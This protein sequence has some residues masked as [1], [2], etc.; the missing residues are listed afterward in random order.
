MIVKWMNVF[1]RRI[2]GYNNGKVS[3]ILESLNY[4]IKDCGCEERA[5]EASAEFFTNKSKTLAFA[6]QA[7]FKNDNDLL[8]PFYG[9]VID[10]K[11]VRKKFNGD[12]DS[13]Y[14]EVR[15]VRT[16]PRKHDIRHCEV[17][18]RKYNSIKGIL[19]VNPP[20]D[21]IYRKNVMS[22]H[23]I[24]KAYAIRHGLKIYEG[25]EEMIAETYR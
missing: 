3:Q 15:E 5:K 13:G 12:I 6:M 1:G 10:R 4:E 22:L 9:L 14:C 8:V 11:A 17:I 21:Y 19:L 18:Y 23:G 20:K 7:M 16:N 25:G 24:I 2:Y